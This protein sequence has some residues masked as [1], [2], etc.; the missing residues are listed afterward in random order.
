MVPSLHFLKPLIQLHGFSCFSLWPA[1]LSLLLIPVGV[2]VQM[3]SFFCS[4]KRR[5]RPPTT[6]NKNTTHLPHHTLPKLQLD[7]ERAGSQAPKGRGKKST[8]NLTFDSISNC[9]STNPTTKT[10]SSSSRSKTKSLL[11][12]QIGRQTKEKGPTSLEPK[13]E[14]F[15]LDP[16]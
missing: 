12:Q 1:S 9:N 3:F 16:H 2:C 6:P 14:P 8:Q 15:N 5:R 13:V 4:P 10:A 11:N 7:K